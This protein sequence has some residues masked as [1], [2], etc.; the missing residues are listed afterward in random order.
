MVNRTCSNIIYNM[1][2]RVRGKMRRER[3]ENQY[4]RLIITTI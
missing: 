2:K 1:L 4:A 3:T